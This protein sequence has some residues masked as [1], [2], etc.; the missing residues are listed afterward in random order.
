[1]RYSARLA[2]V[3]KQQV[4]IF[5]ITAIHFT[6]PPEQPGMTSRVIKNFIKIL[7]LT[8]NWTIAY[9]TE[10]GGLVSR[11]ARRR[12]GFE[13]RILLTFAHCVHYVWSGARFSN[14]KIPFPSLFTKY[15]RRI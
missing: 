14:P 8:C 4:A 11:L 1:M 9:G 5:P 15:Q 7:C 6:W 13:A 10:G 2:G 12:P 3:L